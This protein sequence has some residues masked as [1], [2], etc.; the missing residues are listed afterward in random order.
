MK[1]LFT[2]LLIIFSNSA[3]SVIISRFKSVKCTVLNKTVTTMDFCYIK[4]YSRKYATLNWGQT[5][6]VPMGPPLD[7]FCVL[8]KLVIIKVI[9]IFS[10]IF[11]FKLVLKYRYGTI[12]REVLHVEFEWCSFAQGTTKNP[13]ASIF[14]TVAKASAPG[15]FQGCPFIV[16]T[17]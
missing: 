11:Q 14:V 16:I 7:V 2:F 13:I 3:N 5:I 17:Y 8:C 15:L 12:F 4:A 9:L 1:T 6:H 10:P